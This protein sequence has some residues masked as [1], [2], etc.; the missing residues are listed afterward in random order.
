MCNSSLL[1]FYGIGHGGPL[2]SMIASV[3]VG[4]VLTLENVE[5]RSDGFMQ[6]RVVYM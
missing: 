4:G 5:G 6:P 3:A 1:F 2:T